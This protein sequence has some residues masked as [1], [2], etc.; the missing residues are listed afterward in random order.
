LARHPLD[1]PPPAFVHPHGEKKA[2]HDIPIE[3]NEDFLAQPPAT[4]SD[5]DV[6]ETFLREVDENMR[7]DRTADFFRENKVTLIVALVLFLAASGGLIW[8]EE[9]QK[10]QA[11]HEVE[12]LAEAYKAISEDK[13]ASVPQRL[14]EAAGSS[15]GAIRA[16]ALFTE[17]ALAIEKSD[18]ATAIKIFSDLEADNS[19]PESYRQAALLRRTALEF[20]KLKP[21]EVIS[22]LAPLAKPDSPWFGSAAEMTGAALFKQGKKTEAGK[23]FAQIANDKNA[24]ETLRARSIQIAGSLGVDA[25]GALPPA[26]Q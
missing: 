8:Y 16:S 4:P 18:T 24:P 15:S 2:G 26:A 17:A 9:H 5:S 21:E 12:V 20:D 6:N 7:R 19:L 14:K 1:G 3:R 23:L 11:G 22:R 13:M 25:S 10:N